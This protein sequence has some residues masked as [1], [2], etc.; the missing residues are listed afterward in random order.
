MAIQGTAGSPVPAGILV[1][2]DPPG[3]QDSLV[4]VDTPGIQDSL[5]L[6]GTPGT[7]GSLDSQDS[8]DHQDIVGIRDLE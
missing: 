8:L 3:I 2:Q 4:L 1:I 7:A 6:V 5:V